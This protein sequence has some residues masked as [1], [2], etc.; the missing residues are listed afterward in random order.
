MSETN[1]MASA[2]GIGLAMGLR[3][4]FT[5][6][7]GPRAFVGIVGAIVLHKI[8]S[9]FVVW[10]EK[11]LCTQDGTGGRWVLW[12]RDLKGGVENVDSVLTSV[13][14]TLIGSWIAHLLKNDYRNI[15]VF[16]MTA[17]LWLYMLV[18]HITQRL[19]KPAEEKKKEDEEEEKPPVAQRTPWRN[20]ALVG[21]YSQK[22][23]I[24]APRSEPF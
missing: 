2:S 13:I 5:L 16:Y 4:H 8:L 6:F 9:F 20:D 12:Y 1:L 22:S 24:A 7:Q 21:I 10:L 17:P 19:N 15:P 14:G 11:H 3:E 18:V 23:S